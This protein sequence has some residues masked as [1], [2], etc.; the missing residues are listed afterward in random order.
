MKNLE[1][2][3]EKHCLFSLGYVLEYVKEYNYFKLLN[4]EGTVLAFQMPT[5][6]VRYMWGRTT[7]EEQE[8]LDPIFGKP[9]TRTKIVGLQKPRQQDLDYLRLHGDDE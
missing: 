4:A 6:D 3:Y 7:K 5:Q 2:L 8:V 1:K 9:D